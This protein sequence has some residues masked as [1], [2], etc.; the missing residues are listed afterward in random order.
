M[1]FVE[2]LKLNILQ[3]PI[4]SVCPKF[5]KLCGSSVCFEVFMW[6]REKGEE[7]GVWHLNQSPSASRTPLQSQTKK[8]KTRILKYLEVGFGTIKISCYGNRIHYWL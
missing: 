5:V 2:T 4:T 6:F 3:T 8:L 7:A 1:D